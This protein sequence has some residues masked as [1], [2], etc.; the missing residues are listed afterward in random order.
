MLIAAV[1]L[2]VSAL[3]SGSNW[4]PLFD[5]KSL[6]G[7]TRLNGTASFEAT[8]G[9]IVGKTV[10]GSS[11]TFL[12]TKKMYGDFE[13][14]FEVK[15]ASGLN[16]GVQVRSM[17]VPG[18]QNGRVHGYQVEIDSTN[19]NS[20]GGIYDEA[21]RG[22]LFDP[23][24]QPHGRKAYKVDAW[25][26]FR[27]VAKGTH[28]QTWVNGIACSDVQDD[29]TRWGFIGLQVHES[30][31]SGMEVRWK[32]L[33]IKDLTD[34]GRVNSENDAV[35]PT[36]LP[37]GGK[38][39]LKGAGD[40]SLWAGERD[41][42]SPCPWKWT[43]GFIQSGGGDIMTRES[44]GSSRVHVEFMTDENGKEGQA[45]GNSGV[46]FMQSYEIQVLNSAPRGPLNNECGAIYSVKAPDYAMAF[47]A[48]KWQSY[49]VE[50]TA[51][52]WTDGKKVSPARI[53][54]YHNGTLIHRN[55]EIPGATVA[56]KEEAEG[57]RPLRLQDHGNQVRYRNIWIAP[58]K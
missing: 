35:P 38:W 57:A 18:Y 52:V 30:T 6:D 1:I 33:R 12:C 27:V 51:P 5:G 46:Y 41:P 11:N 45:N 29:L 32:N 16:S 7:W 39:L 22:W 36:V 28:L 21:R 40:L 15:V 26:K 2:G 44:F 48:G 34:R 20:S 3:S 58:V 17:S 43:D 23:S 24:K 42:K 47:P 13:L 31:T 4:E 56:G 55:V 37:K 49:D 53:T 8:R 19:P 54:A 9:E 50:F 14:E 25:N 10:V